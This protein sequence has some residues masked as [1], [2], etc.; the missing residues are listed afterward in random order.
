[1]MLCPY[2]AGRQACCSEKTYPYPE[3]SFVAASFFYVHSYYLIWLWMNILLEKI[4]DGY[5]SNQ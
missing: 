3:H 5:L 2:V 4:D 1:M